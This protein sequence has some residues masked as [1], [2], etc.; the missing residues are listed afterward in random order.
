MGFLPSRCL[1]T[2]R[3]LLLSRCLAKIRAD[4]Q[5][6]RHADSNVISYFQDE[7]TRIKSFILFMSASENT[8]N[9]SEPCLKAYGSEVSVEEGG[10]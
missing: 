1:A 6:D 5:T 8:V 10:R 9:G 3:G 7:E 2:I 4:T